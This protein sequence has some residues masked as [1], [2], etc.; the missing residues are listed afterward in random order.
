MRAGIGLVGLLIAVA[1]I[2]YLFAESGIPTIKSGEKAKEQVRQ[3]GGRGQDSVPATE[4]FATTG[5]MKGS[6]LAALQVSAVT[7]GGAMDTYYGL[8]Q[9]DEIIEI[10]GMT[11]DT[12]SGDEETAKTLVVSEG[13]QKQQPLTV[14]RG[15]QRVTLPLIPGG[16]PPASADATSTPP[17]D[18][19]APPAPVP[20]TPAAPPKPRGL[21]GQLQDIQDAAGGQREN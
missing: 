6:K 3:I 4:S 14:R 15:G 18:G 7:P 16:V 5:Q 19:T 11:L 1:L 9:G 2:V 13:Y 10:G 21:Q 8:K 12:L 20:A 17:S